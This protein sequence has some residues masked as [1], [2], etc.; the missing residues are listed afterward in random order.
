M[1]LDCG[2]MAKT[3]GLYVPLGGY[4]GARIALGTPVDQPSCQHS[5]NRSCQTILCGRS[6]NR[7]AWVKSD[8]VPA[9]NQIRT[10]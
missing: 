10:Y 1:K 3:P 2:V 7:E 9:A 6:V 8:A 4:R 5:H